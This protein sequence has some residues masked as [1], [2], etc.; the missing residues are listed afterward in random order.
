[1]V[2]AL[3]ASMLG[4]FHSL[5][6]TQA[7]WRALTALVNSCTEKKSALTSGITSSGRLW[8]KVPESEVW[9]VGKAMLSKLSCDFVDLQ[10]EG[11]A[12]TVGFL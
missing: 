3:H 1:M 4:C 9:C 7:F 12:T 2:D 6:H 11:N 5:V 8:R 10:I